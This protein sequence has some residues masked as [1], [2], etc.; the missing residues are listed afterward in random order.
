MPE[1]PFKE[2]VNPQSTENRSECGKNWRQPNRWNRVLS[3]TKVTKVSK[4]KGK[5]RKKKGKQRKKKKLRRAM[6][7]HHAKMWR[8]KKV[9]RRLLKVGD[10]MIS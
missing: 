6:E 5:Q 3:E 8:F 2:D 10:I 1:N 9:G 7:R 4:R